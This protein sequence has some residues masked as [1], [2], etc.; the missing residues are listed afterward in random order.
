MAKFTQQHYKR[1]GYEG[2]AW[3]VVGQP[4]IQSECQGHPDNTGMAPDDQFE[5]GQTYYCDGSC[6]EPQPDET[7]VIAVMVGD[8]R[9]HTFDADELVPISDN[10]FC[11]EC[12]QIGCGHGR[13]EV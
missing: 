8:D 13:V 10:E 5:S 4:M 12:G 2:I 1:D 11:S 9:R 3:R 7:R 6:E